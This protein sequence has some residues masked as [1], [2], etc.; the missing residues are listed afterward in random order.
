MLFIG[1]LIS[2]L[3]GV[4]SGKFSPI[5]WHWVI[6]LIILVVQYGIGVQ[7]LFSTDSILPK[8]S[9][10]PEA[11]A[12]LLCWAPGTVITHLLFIRVRKKTKVN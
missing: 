1:I 6:L 11:F 9:G 4:L 10:I 2:I 8:I 3:S 5:K 12:G 7:E